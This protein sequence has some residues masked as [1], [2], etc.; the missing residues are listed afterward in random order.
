MALY[1]ER[2]QRKLNQGATKPQS[3]VTSK[4]IKQGVKKFDYMGINELK[5][6]ENGI[7]DLFEE[8]RQLTKYLSH[9]RPAKNSSSCVRLN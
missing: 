2:L 6:H 4:P 1:D 7:M 8:D 3:P 9:N 5:Q